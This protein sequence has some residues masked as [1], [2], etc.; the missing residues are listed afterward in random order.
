M[1]YT[2]ECKEKLSKRWIATEKLHEVVENEKHLERG[3]S[4][5]E[6]LGTSGVFWRAGQ[7]QPWPHLQ[8]AEPHAPGE[9]LTL[10]PSDQ[11]RLV[12]S[13]FGEAH[14]AAKQATRLKGDRMVGRVLQRRRSGSRYVRT[15]IVHWLGLSK[16]VQPA[17]A[18]L[19]LPLLLWHFTRPLTRKASI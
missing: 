14:W 12:W 3:C 5:G 4:A 6:R 2:Q 9:I 17:E 13:F 15:N 10:L 19:F 1:C 8:H 16:L 7:V 11:I 18:N